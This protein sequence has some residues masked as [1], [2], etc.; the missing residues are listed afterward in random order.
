M[1]EYISY[2]F[3]MSA[4]IQVL[5][6]NHLYPPQFKSSLSSIPPNFNPVVAQFKSSLG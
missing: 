4:K 2:D 3:V 1:S 5:S 6:L